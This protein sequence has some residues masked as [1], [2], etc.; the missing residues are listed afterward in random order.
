MIDQNIINSIKLLTSFTDEELGIVMKYFVPK[1]IKKKTILLEAGITAK[2]IYF[3]I[4]GCIRL[5]YTKDGKDIS[6]YFFTE[7]MFA[8]AYDSFISKKPSRHS[9]ETLEDCQILTISDK[10][11]QELYTELPKMNEFVRKVLE[12]RFVSLHELYTS[13]IL[14][15]PEERYVNLLNNRP[16]LINRIPQHQIATFLGITPVSLSRIRNRILKK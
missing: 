6:A 5:F 1:N 7:K 16:D 15:T 12:E 4:S 14:D 3:V 11:S 10:A 9:I 8:G 13:Q 2:E